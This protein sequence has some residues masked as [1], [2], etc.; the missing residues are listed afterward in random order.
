MNLAALLAVLVAFS[1]QDGGTPPLDGGTAAERP[2]DR[3]DGG[4]GGGSSDGGTGDPA[5]GGADVDPE[6]LRHLD[7]LENLELL[8]HLELFDSRAEPDRKP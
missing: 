7:E 2:G 8:Q 3:A 4:E 5:D 6:I 1:P